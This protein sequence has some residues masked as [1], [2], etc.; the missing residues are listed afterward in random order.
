MRIFVG[1]DPREVPAVTVCARSL[2]R[3][4]SVPLDI[5][6]LDLREL[7]DAGLYQRPHEYREG[8][9]WDVISNRPMSTQFAIS[10]FLVPHLCEY[11]GWALYVDCDFLFRA[12]VAELFALA[13]ERYAV[14]CVQHC[15]IPRTELKMDGQLNL[16]YRRKNWSSLMLW[17]CGHP[18][19]RRLTPD[20][21]N[22]RH[23]D[24]LHGFAWLHEWHIGALPTEWNWIEHEP[25]AVHF[26]YGTPDV[27]GHERAAYAEEYRGYLCEP[28]A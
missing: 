14:M 5:T 11:R 2:V 12:D 20:F 24:D 28:A 10:R 27:A 22:T 9:L 21:V 4:A 6:K 25:R 18:F 15:Y 23:R 8:R 7:R 3:H 16:A 26:T 19:N 17:N 1:Y 13:N